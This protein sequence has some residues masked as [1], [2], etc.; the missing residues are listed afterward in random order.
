MARKSKI[1]WTESTWNPITGCT[2]ISEGCL[3]CYAE[4]MAFRLKSMGV[5]KY[6]NG[7]DITLHSENLGDPLSWAKP[8]IIFV[9]SMSDLFHDEVPDDYIL[10]VFK[11]MNDAN[12]HVFQVLTKRSKRLIELNDKIEWTS[13]I[14]MGVTVESD[15][16]VY[17]I[18]D[19]VNTDAKIKFLSLEPLLSDIP[20]IML[21]NIDWVIVGGES[22]FN[23]RS[24]RK[25]WVNSIQY[26]CEIENVPFFF[27]QWGGVNKK[28]SGRTLDGKIWS[29]MPRD[30]NSEIHLNFK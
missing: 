9:C 10:K 6:K 23:A 25:N 12:W 5:K 21:T 16:H 1:E 29:Q 7:F 20:K 3:N 30:F 24:I 14:W 27:K 8:N 22:G 26:Q 11:T 13:N 2:K 15:R 17:R 18:D 28:K 4:K 19:L